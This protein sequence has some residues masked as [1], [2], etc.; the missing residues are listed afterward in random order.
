MNVLVTGGAGQLG[1]DVVAVLRENGHRARIFSRR[2]REGDDWAQGELATGAGID[3]ALDGMDAAIHAASATRD[4]RRGQA[5]DVEGT[6][7]LVDGAARAHIEHFVHVSI[8]G[9]DRVASTYYRAK[10]GAEQV[11]R[12]ATIPWSI[13]RATQFHSYI[14]FLIGR[15]NRLPFFVTVPFAWQF[16]PVD[17]RDVANR[18]VGVVA[19]NPSGMLAD[20]G[21]PEVRHLNTLAASWREATRSRK[22]LVNLPLPT[23]FS[24]QIAQGGLLCPDHRDGKTTFEEYLVRRYGQW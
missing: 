5:T 12:Q 18:L 9:V 23:T 13:L 3:A 16:Q 14:E 1:S 15:F 24:R 4:P 8:V 6:R 17:V 7:N 19:G 21:G 10:L 11:V 22:R 20:F 2:P